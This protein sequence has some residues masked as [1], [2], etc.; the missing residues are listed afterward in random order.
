LL[1]DTL[2]KDRAETI[3]LQALA[4]L[5][6]DPEEIDRFLHASGLEIADLR[7]KAGDPDLL[8]AVLTFILA[9]DTRITGLCQEL[10]ITAHDLHSANHVLGQP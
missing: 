8:G 10:N 5:A 3:A 2:T 7:G 4:F 9:D 1:R 6:S